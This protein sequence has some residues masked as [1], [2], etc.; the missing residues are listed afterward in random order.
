MRPT[1]SGFSNMASWIGENTVN[2][3]SDPIMKNSPW[4]KFGMFITPN[5]RAR[6]P[7]IMAHMPPVTRVSTRIEGR[8]N[9]DRISTRTR[10]A[11]TPQVNVR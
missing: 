4:A 2:A 5:T 11:M 1:I 6:P 3:T 10:I 9:A 7:A 8:T